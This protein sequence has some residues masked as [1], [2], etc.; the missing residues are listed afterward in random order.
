MSE[1]N[2]NIPPK[3]RP[4][5]L[6]IDVAKFEQATDE[7][8]AQQEVMRESTTF[9]RDGMRKLFRNPLAV[10]SMIVLLVILVTIII[11]P[12]IVPYS[13]SG[14][15]TVNGKRDKSAKNLTPFTYSKLEQ[16]AIDEGEYI[17]P[18]IFGTDEL[19]R[20]Y[21]IRVIFGARVSLA[22]G[23]F[24]SLIV[25]IIGLLPP[26]SSC[27]LTLARTRPCASSWL[28]SRISWIPR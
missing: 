27:M 15:I 2:P 21:F 22:V 19:C 18:H 12:M 3:K 13:Y 17:F 9:F 6:Q 25:L 8:K 4:F 26:S 24:A 16:Q 7:E 10:G 23:F 20:D 28:P 1:Y 5:S 14:M 11:A